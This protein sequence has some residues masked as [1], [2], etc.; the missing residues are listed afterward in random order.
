MGGE[1]EGGA[2]GVG[3]RGRGVAFAGAHPWVGCSTPV[4]T[5][6]HAKRGEDNYSKSTAMRMVI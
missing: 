2:G 4:R 1:G 3:W 6:M 5:S